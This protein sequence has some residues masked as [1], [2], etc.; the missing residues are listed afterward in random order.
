MPDAHHQLPLPEEEEEG[1]MHSETTPDG[2]AGEPKG[3]MVAHKIGEGAS[4]QHVAGAGGAEKAAFG[5][6]VS[7]QAVMAEGAEGGNDGGNG[8]AERGGILHSDEQNTMSDAAQDDVWSPGGGGEA[9]GDFGEQPEQL[10]GDSNLPEDIKNRVAGV[11]RKVDDTIAAWQV[12]TKRLRVELHQQVNDAMD[13]IDDKVKSNISRL[14]VDEATLEKCVAKLVTA[15]TELGG[16]GDLLLH[17]S[18][19]IHSEN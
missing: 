1:Q 17:F 2:A 16:V 13:L 5:A 19:R 10:Q 6:A 9:A 7:G 18:S 3:A 15:R 8:C 4:Q 11:K 14:D 12:H